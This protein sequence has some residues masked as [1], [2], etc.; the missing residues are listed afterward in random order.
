MHH[1]GRT[2]SRRR[3][4]LAFVETHSKINVVDGN[5]FLVDAIMLQCDIMASDPMACGCANE[6][7]PN[8][9]IG[10]PRRHKASRFLPPLKALAG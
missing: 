4:S 8:V 7:D 9:E 2:Y 6:L 10:S 1:E 5:K 3:A